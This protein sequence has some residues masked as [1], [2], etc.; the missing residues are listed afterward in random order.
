MVPQKIVTR[1]E[2]L[3]ERKQHLAREK[4][5]TRLR[6]DVSRQRRALPWVK[7]DK[8]YVF[9][10]PNGSESL[11][12]MFEGRNQLIVYHFMFGPDW[13]EGCPSCSFLS[14]HFDP[15]LIHLAHRDTTLRVVSRAL[16]DRLEAFRKRMG[17]PFQWVS[18]LANDF[19]FDFDVSFPPERI[20]DG[21][22][23]YN[24]TSFDAA[25]G[26]PEEAHGI[27]VF[28]KDDDGAIYH[29]YSSY[30]RGADLLLGTYNFLDLVPKGRDED[31]F[32]FPMTWMR[33]HDRYDGY[34]L[35]PKAGYRM[36]AKVC[37]HC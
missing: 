36:P 26:M 13:S 14:D 10:G 27:S 37:S 18:S 22:M 31:S 33:H 7:I 24:Y 20:V 32:P 35:D 9:E 8:S 19:N 12:D 23:T 17:W 3:I 6:D 29:T 4:E 21:K 11:S 2:W 28:A 15:T 1:D 30:A 16:I 25:A 5:L 34:A